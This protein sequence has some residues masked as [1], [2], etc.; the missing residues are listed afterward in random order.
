MKKLTRLGIGL[1]LIL[2][3]MSDTVQAQTIYNSIWLTNQASFDIET[4]DSIDCQLENR[5]P[6]KPPPPVT[7]PPGHTGAKSNDFNGDGKA[8][9]LLYDLATGKLVM[10][11]M[12]GTTAHSAIIVNAT[13]TT[14]SIV[15]T[16]DFDGDGKAD[17][18][19][20]DSATGKLVLWLMDG[21]RIAGG[22]LIAIV[23]DPHWQVAGSGDLNGDKKADL[24]W[25]HAPDG[26]VVGWLMNGTQIL[27]GSIVAEVS[28]LGWQIA[29]VADL[30]GNGKA[31]LVWRHTPTGAVAAWLMN[32]L[33]IEQAA[34]IYP[35]VSISST[36]QIAGIKDIDGDGKADILW[37][38]R[39]T[40]VLAVWLMDGVT[41]RGATIA[42]NI[43]WQ[44]KPMLVDD[45]DGDG[46]ADILWRFSCAQEGAIFYMNGANVRSGAKISNLPIEWNFVFGPEVNPLDCPSG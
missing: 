45:I 43:A 32:G 14:W 21:A 31:D 7:K 17:I 13:D 40:G 46:K 19:W 9:I 24:V 35:G 16:Q 25:Y 27:Q 8:D 23:A 5:C 34:G 29:G 39:T 18:L 15:S 11:L 22:G 28:D 2:V 37:H 33:T 6:S 42:T 41:A 12:D 26:Q 4:A 38:D 36:W 30:D 20:H 10:W 3:G 1:G 44:W